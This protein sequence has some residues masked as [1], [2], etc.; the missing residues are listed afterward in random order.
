MC[1]EYQTFFDSNNLNQLKSFLRE[2]STKEIYTDHFTKYSV[3]LIRS[4][5]GDCS[6]RILGKDFELGE[7]NS[8]SWVLYNKEHIDELKLQHFEYP[9]FSVLECSEFKLVASFK[10]FI[11]YEKLP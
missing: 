11:F 7:I 4:Y 3:D 6:D 9:D 10:D 5:D 2:N 1:F 8:G